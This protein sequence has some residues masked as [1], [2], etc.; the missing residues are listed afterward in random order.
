MSEKLGRIMW[1]RID[2]ESF[3]EDCYTDLMDRDVGDPHRYRPVHVL[4]PE[5]LRG[6]LLNAFQA[7]E[8]AAI[9]EPGEAGDL[10]F[11]DYAKELGL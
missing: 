7:G 2:D 11:D 3:P 9:S 1:A 6:L 10:F 4:T 8:Q 5:E